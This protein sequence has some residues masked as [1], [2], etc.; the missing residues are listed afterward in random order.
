VTATGGNIDFRSAVTLSSPVTVQATS[1]HIEF[2]STVDSATSTPEALTL[3]TL[4]SGN[5]LLDGAAGATHPLGALLVNSVGTFVESAGITATSVD[6]TATNGVDLN[7]N[8]T[9]TNGAVDFRS[10][11]SLLSPIT[12]QA[13]SGH[14]EFHSTVDSATSTPE[15]LTLTTLT[16]GDILLD[17]AAGATHPLGA[18]LVNSAGQFTESAGITATSVNAIAM[19]GITLNGDVTTTGPFT[20]NADSDADGTGT[21]TLADGKTI[22]TND[23]VLHITAADVELGTGV[24]DSG[25]ANT[26]IEASNCETV[27]LGSAAGQGITITEAQLQN[28]HSGSLTIGGLTTGNIT[29]DGVTT[30]SQQGP[31]TLLAECAN[32]TLT[33]SGNGSQFQALTGN[34]TGTISVQAS[35]Q[36]SGNIALISTGSEVD[37]NA[38]VTATATGNVDVTGSTAIGLD[39]TVTTAGGNVTF[40]SPVVLTGTSAVNSGGGNVSFD[41]TVDS[42]ASQGFGVTVNGGT[43]GAVLFQGAVGGAVNG[44]LGNLLVSQS[45]NVTAQSSLKAA[46]IDLEATNGITLDGDVTT[47]AASPN[48]TFTA[49]ADTDANGTGTFTLANG[50]IIQTNNSVLHITAADVQ[51]GTGGLNSGTANTTIEASD[52][53]TVGLGSAAGQDITITEAQL[54]NIHSGSLTIGGANT[55][56]I[57]V[58]AVTTTTQQGTMTLTAGCPSPAATITFSGANAFA[59]LSGTA[60]G[61]IV[62]DNNNTATITVTPGDVF[63]QTAGIMTVNGTI[64]TTPGMNGNLSI[65]GAVTLNAQPV[66]GK[67]NITLIANGGLDLVINTPEIS[68]KS[69]NLSAPRDIIVKA[70][71]ET[72][73]SAD[74][75]ITLTADT[76]H[77]GVG[78]VWITSTGE[79]IAAGNV[80]ISG[81]NLYNPGQP[82]T[83]VDSILVDKNAT[84]G[85]ASITA[86]GSITLKSG[87]DAPAGADIVLHG[88]IV[89]TGTGGVDVTA[90]RDIQMDTTIDGGS[91][92]VSLTATSGNV[93]LSHVVTKSTV[94]VQAA[95]A[96]IN[97]LNPN[98]GENITALAAGLSARTGIGNSQPLETSVGTLAAKNT[99][100]GNIVI[101]NVGGPLT[102]GTVGTIAGIEND[103]PL[104][105]VNVTNAGALT[106]DPPVLSTKGGNILLTSTPGPANNLTINAPVRATGGNGNV[107]LNAGNNLVVNGG[108]SGP[109]IQ[110]QGTG[111]ITGTAQNAVVFNGNVLIQTG[112]GAI[113]QLS[114]NLTNVQ[115]PEISAGG[116]ATLTGSYSEPAG[117]YNYTVVVNWGDGTTST[118][119]FTNPSSAGSFVFTHFYPSNPDAVNKSAPIPVTVTVL[120]DPNITFTGL[121]QPAVTTPLSPTSS[122][123]VGND[124]NTVNTQFTV[125]GEGLGFVNIAQLA[126]VIAQTQSTTPSMLSLSPVI[127]P[128]Q[129][130]VSQNLGEQVN[131]FDDTVLEDR[132]VFLQ[133]LDPNGEVTEQVTMDENV[134]DDLPGLFRK[135]P[136]GHYQILLKEPGEQRLRLL[137]DVRLRGGKPADESEESQDMAPAGDAA[138]LEGAGA[139]ETG[140]VPAASG[141]ATLVADPEHGP[142]RRPWM[143]EAG[144]PEIEFASG[145]A[146]AA[147][148]DA[149]EASRPAGAAESGLMTS[150]P[151]ATSVMAA[152]A[153]ASVAAG[154]WS[155]RL[156]AALAEAGAQALSKVARLSR[157]LRRPTAPQAGVRRGGSRRGRPVS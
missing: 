55:G 132:Q 87:P 60:V 88:A 51:L 85:T 57:A 116:I 35:V 97:G 61:N 15:G 136:D 137:L 3:T 14:I 19:S 98:T 119:T 76:D 94:F 53:E 95:G 126:V 28:I 120:D 135:L 13:T 152:G 151:G 26:T 41:S 75:N 43:N 33:F 124:F 103:A 90:A 10:A 67:G 48:A 46:A 106:V 105:N 20:A 74:G 68:A 147:L 37:L 16:S 111:T 101:N 156:D 110:T 22:Q 30:D 115:T 99:S 23:S 44:G 82:N 149:E 157:R 108:G 54:Q 139:V 100:S 123:T 140:L 52:C 62:V 89:S 79:I 121:H 29:V 80:T 24:L 50:A 36:A 102:I 5:I 63:L 93:T 148:F 81:S 6:A 127:P 78:G 133:V 143:D 125:P 92:P 112:A 11:V 107:V 114:P 77:D 4:T 56:S 113:T 21:F 154:D 91:G 118:Q 138:G 153:L 47:T 150:R 58:D 141:N 84:P 49:N 128:P 86:A 130:T 7:G 38:M 145:A 8:V 134:L 104:G 34:A 25:T 72:T 39:T 131:S 27:G 31:V 42:Q 83:F 9:A 1:G 117:A 109:D 17:G 18:L 32:S 45:G 2:H 70:L 64:S 155:E 96:I 69:I 142:G 129:L 65:T 66:L 40:H 12:V 122:Q 144:G 73:N 59:G 71:L 146:V